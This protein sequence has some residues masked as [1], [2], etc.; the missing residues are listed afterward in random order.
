M[1]S[2]GLTRQPSLHSIPL[3]R[4]SSWLSSA[5]SSQNLPFILL[6][7][8]AEQRTQSCRTVFFAA[9]SAILYGTL[10]IAMNFTNKAALMVFPYANCLL[11]LQMLAALVIIAPLKLVGAVKFPPLNAT[12]A[13]A[14]L[15]VTI[16]YAGNVSCALVGLKILNV[17]MYSTLKRLTP[18]I[19]LLTKWRMT[20][21]LPSRGVIASVALVVV[22]CLVAGYGDIGVSFDL[23]GY[24][25]AMAS[26][27]L[28]AAYLL[29]VEHSGAKQGVS[30]SEL[31]TYNALLSLPFILAVIVI[32]GESATAMSAWT[33]AATAEGVSRVAVL[34]LIC[35]VSGVALNFSMFLCASINSALTTTIVSSLK[36]VVATTLGFFL[37]GGV[38]FHTVN[39]VGIAL[40]VLGG[41]M[42]SVV[43]YRSRMDKYN[44]SDAGS[45]YSTPKRHHPR[46]VVIPGSA[47]PVTPMMVPSKDDSRVPA[48]RQHRTSLSE[49]TIFNN[50]SPA[51][52]AKSSSWGSQSSNVYFNRQLEV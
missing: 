48:M 15:P 17:P 22:G 31:L 6:D 3:E 9:G 29:L 10:A 19:V 8:E 52:S 46:A 30:T 32:S 5:L 38:E 2:P 1:K 13:R 12:K 35:A 41:S 4:H 27:M 23:R 39:V 7:I 14:L 24:A 33:A 11:L 51:G 18:M 40:N 49:L 42:Y 45:M 47:S 25:F 34:L 37:L 44:T 16:L 26:C 50:S 36:G 28:Q 43:K 21:E 20:K